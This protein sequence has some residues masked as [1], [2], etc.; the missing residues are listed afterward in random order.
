MNVARF[1]LQRDPDTEF[2]DPTEEESEKGFTALLWSAFRGCEELVHL[3]ID[4]GADIDARSDEGKAQLI[5]RENKDM[6]GFATIY[7]K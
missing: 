4:K 7:K 6:D 1:A 5:A 3:L 2:T